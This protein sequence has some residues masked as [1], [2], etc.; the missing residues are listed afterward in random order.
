MAIQKNNYEAFNKFQT[1]F[2]TNVNEFNNFTNYEIKE[3]SFTLL[4]N[5]SKGFPALSA[6]IMNVYCKDF[7]SFR[8]CPTLIKAL[9]RKFVNGFFRAK[10]PQFIYYKTPKVT[11]LKVTKAKIGKDLVD[12]SSDIIFEIKSILMY[13]N[14]TFEYYKYSD[15]VQ[16]LGKQLASEFERSEIEKIKKSSKT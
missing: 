11:K 10:F 2:Y 8:E 4:V 12:F 13:D 5:M 16:R 7:I 6:D 15:K 9:Q 1:Y 14:K 3:H